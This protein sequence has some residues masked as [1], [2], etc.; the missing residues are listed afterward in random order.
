MID[1]RL[2]RGRDYFLLYHVV[3]L[4]SQI[5]YYENLHAEVS[6]LENFQVF[7]GWLRVDIKFFKAS[8]LNT[9]K[10]WSWLF[11]EHLF[12]YVTNR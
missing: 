12:T 3:V 11:K 2:M 9:I 8:L 10:K 1:G 5:D 4:I 6:Q 7:D